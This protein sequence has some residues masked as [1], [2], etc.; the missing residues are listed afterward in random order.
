VKGKSAGRLHPLRRIQG[1]AEEM[2]AEALVAAAATGDVAAM[3]VLFD[4]FHESVHRFLG[5][6]VP[7]PDV[8]DVLHATFM[9][10]FAAA[11]RY[12]GG[13]AVRTWLFGIALNVSRHHRRGETR[14]RA[15]LAGLETHP[16]REAGQPDRLA[17][18]RQLVERVTV[19]LAGLSHERRAVFLLCDVEELSGAEAAR[20][21]GAPVGTVGRW[22][23][24][25]RAAV[26]AALREEAG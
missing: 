14:R 7:A 12:R 18:S 15:F 19:A 24:E 22:L 26:R 16:Q 2:S 11:H 6:L 23:F 1:N 21:L 10:A 8:D 5:R 9:E 4:R 25:A 17:E 3:A 20:A 13:S